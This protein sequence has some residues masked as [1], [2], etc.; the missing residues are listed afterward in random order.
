L[1]VVCYTSY[2]RVNFLKSL[3]ILLHFKNRELQVPFCDGP[4][5][6]E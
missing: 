1:G 6:P 2:Y 3:F 5:N 4:D